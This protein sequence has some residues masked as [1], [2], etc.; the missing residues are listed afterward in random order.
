[1]RGMTSSAV[2]ALV[3]A[4]GIEA[5]Q[6]KLCSILG[7]NN[8]HIYTSGSLYGLLDSNALLLIMRAFLFKVLK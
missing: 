3:S 6:H 7:G 4:Y 5:L 8:S 1:M 2:E